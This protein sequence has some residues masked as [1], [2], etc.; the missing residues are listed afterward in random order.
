MRGITAASRKGNA[1]FAR[2]P[3]SVLTGGTAAVGTNVP[4]NADSLNHTALPFGANR[5]VVVATDASNVLLLASQG[6][7]VGNY[8]IRIMHIT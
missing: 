1:A 6:N 5:Y 3:A 2:M 8:D 4:N 7:A